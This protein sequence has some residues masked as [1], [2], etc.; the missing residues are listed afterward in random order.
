[1]QS[2]FNLYPRGI[3]PKYKKNVNEDGLYSTV[4]T[5]GISFDDN[6][7]KVHIKVNIELREATLSSFTCALQYY[8]FLSNEFHLY[9]KRPKTWIQFDYWTLPL[10]SC[11]SNICPHS[12][13]AHMCT[14]RAPFCTK[15]VKTT[16]HLQQR[17]SQKRM[18]ERTHRRSETYI[19]I[20]VFVY[21]RQE[22]ASSSYTQ[23]LARRNVS[24]SFLF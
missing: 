22:K 4:S 14:T 1:M 13:T 24:S 16:K 10:E 6:L 18:T 11:C 8:K 15:Q 19:S 17:I 9:R 12:L 21:P 5:R 3:S 20:E 7:L 23:T 2:L